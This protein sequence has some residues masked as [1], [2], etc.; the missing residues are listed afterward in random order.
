MAAPTIAE[1]EKQVGDLTSTVK[2]LADKPDF[3]GVRRDDQGRVTSHWDFED[4]GEDVT[5]VTGRDDLTNMPRAERA[6]KSYKVN[7]KRLMRQHKYEPYAEFKSFND[8]VRSGLDTHQTGKFQDRMSRH[9]KAIQGM[10]DSIG[11]DGGFTVIP[12]FNLKIHQRVYGNDLFGMTDNYQVSGNNMTFLAN[13]ET[14]RTDG[15]RAGGIRG[16]WT[17]EGNTIASSKP[18]VREI[19]MRLNK[20]CV[21]V[22]LTDELIADNGTML[23]QYVAQKA[24]DEFNFL[25]GAGVFRGTGAGQP[26]GIIYA[27]SFL[28]VN[29]EA[30]QTTKTVVTENIAKIHGR[31][32][33]PFYQNAS[34]FLNQDVQ[35]QLTTLSLG[36]GTAGV[37]TF[38][39]PGGMSAAPY[40]AILGR[41]MKPI[42]FASTLGTVGDLVC[43]DLSQVLSISK[44]GISQAV[45]MHVEF[46]TDQTALR[47]TMRID[48][49][50][51][52]NAPTTP[53]QGTNTQSSFVG[54]AAR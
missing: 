37:V 35:Q 5:I 32:F 47:F 7:M 54:V 31:V 12:E 30:G 8:F 3:S 48:A 6:S 26:L 36:L 13:A 16:Y 33:A 14:S 2:S 45:S 23:E 43:A 28:A 27:P 22:Y 10:S 19:Q 20:V 17:A 38:M 44:G 15:N 9:F 24:S 21:I 41:P 50:P 49:K 42:E 40:A 11:S 46:L 18:T 34:W 29:A 53:Y 1:L 25:I 52:E 4:E 51:W 39:P